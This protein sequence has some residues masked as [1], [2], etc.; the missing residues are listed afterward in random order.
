MK[1]WNIEV[2]LLDEQGNEKPANCF[3][4]VVYNLHPTFLNPVQSESPTSISIAL[5]IRL[6]SLH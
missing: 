1:S 5:L 2:Y 3:T 4:K 6:Y